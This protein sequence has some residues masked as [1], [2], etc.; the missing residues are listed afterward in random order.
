M[1]IF[2]FPEMAKLAAAPD[3]GSGE[4]IRVGSTPSFGTCLVGEIGKHERLKISCLRACEFNSHT[5]HFLGVTLDR[6]RRVTV[7]HVIRMD[8]WF[9]S[10]CSH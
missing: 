9:D 1:V 7:N 6:F 8:R 3:L 10:I 5:G 2:C 4:E